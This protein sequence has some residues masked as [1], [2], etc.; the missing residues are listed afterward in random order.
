MEAAAETTMTTAVVAGEVARTMIAADAE[1]AM[2][3]MMTVVAAVLAAAHRAGRLL[4][5]AA[6]RHAAARLAVAVRHH[7][8]AVPAVVAVHPQA[9]AAVVALQGVVRLQDAAAAHQ[10]ATHLLQDAEA[11]LQ[12][13]EAAAL[14]GVDHL[15]AAAPAQD[16]EAHHRLHHAVAAARAAKEVLQQ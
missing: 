9:A 16:A 5:D 15:L 14:Q 4:R 11:A 13:V 2:T 12:D 8:V 3:T 1:G 6:A 10:E 7:A